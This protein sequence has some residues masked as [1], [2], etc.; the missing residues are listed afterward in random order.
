MK[1]FLCNKEINGKYYYDWAG[2]CVCDKHYPH[3]VKCA[4][5]GQFCNAHAKEIGRGKKI[6]T[7]CQTYRIEHEDA[8]KVLNFIQSIYTASPI[9]RVANW[10]LQMVSAERM[11]EMT[12][13]ESTR[14][15]AQACGTNYTIFIFRE[16]SR[17]AFAQVLAHEMLHVYQY[18]HHISPSKELCEGFCNL[19]SFVILEKIHT[20]EAENAI[21]CLKEN[22]DP[23]YGDGFR[24]MLAAYQEGGW[25]AALRKLKGI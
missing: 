14:G 9:G 20:K 23:I 12:S 19:G 18:V 4:S 21:K 1:C 10:N 5:C 24:V 3:I 25:N 7:H 11:F 6:C 22:P 17:V 16:L 13:E 8:D 2:H 15:L